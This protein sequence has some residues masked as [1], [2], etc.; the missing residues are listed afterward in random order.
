MQVKAVWENKKQYLDL[1]LLA[2]EQESMIDRYLERG[3]MFALFDD[4]LRTVCVVTD[5]GGGVLEVKNLATVPQFQGQ[6]WGRQMLAW[7]TDAVVFGNRTLLRIFFWKTM[8]IQYMKQ[9]SSC[10]I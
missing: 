4:G 2:D 5:E 3:A 7:L 10:E 8:I 9:E 6:G 1:L